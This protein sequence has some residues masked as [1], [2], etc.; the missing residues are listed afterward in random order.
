MEKLGFDRV[1]KVSRN[2]FAH[3]VV[4]GGPLPLPTKIGRLLESVINESRLQLPE[5][6]RFEGS[7]IGALESPAYS[8]SFLFPNS[9]ADKW[10]A[11]HHAKFGKKYNSAASA[12]KKELTGWATDPT[13]KLSP[14]Q[15]KFMVALTTNF[16]VP[17]PKKRITTLADLISN[18]GER[19]LLVGERH[20]SVG[21]VQIMR[22]M[23]SL[24]EESEGNDTKKIDMLQM[25]H[26]S[27]ADMSLIEK[28]MIS[29]DTENLKFAMNKRNIEGFTADL[30]IG[31]CGA[32]R[33]KGI[34]IYGIDNQHLVSKALLESNININSDAYHS[35]FYERNI[36]MSKEIVNNIKQFMRKNPGQ[37]PHCMIWVGDMHSDFNRTTQSGTGVNKLLP[38]LLAVD[39]WEEGKV[40]E[41]NYD[42]NKIPVKLENSKVG[43]SDYVIDPKK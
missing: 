9:E 43:D 42:K 18:L 3:S 19:P 5:S 37:I 20:G 22:H 12:L 28:F 8:A 30:Y 7:S 24:S 32:V 16:E 14:E 6:L 35:T 2:E 26:F 33:K 13:N 31:V 15:Y 27:H 23:I 40:I 41:G 17:N 4:G 38:G 29:G 1:T 36:S 34:H 10:L 11:E 25:E 21:H 39:F